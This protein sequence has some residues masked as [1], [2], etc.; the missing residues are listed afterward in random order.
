VIVPPKLHWQVEVASAQGMPPMLADTDGGV[1][2]AP[3]A[4]THG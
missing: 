1:Q 4:G 2:G 3:V